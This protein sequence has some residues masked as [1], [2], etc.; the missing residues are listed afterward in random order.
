M[1]V[2]VVWKRCAELIGFRIAYKWPFMLFFGVA[3][4]IQPDSSHGE[5]VAVKDLADLLF[6][7]GGELCLCRAP[8]CLVALIAPAEGVERKREDDRYYETANKPVFHDFFLICFL[9]MHASTAPKGR[10]AQPC[11]RTIPWES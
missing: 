6:G 5:F 7:L 1:P 10:S 11:I 8:D 4:S 2:R 3:R 9:Q